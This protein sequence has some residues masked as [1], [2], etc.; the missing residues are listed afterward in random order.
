VGG[1]SGDETRILLEELVDAGVLATRD[2]PA[3]GRYDRHLLY[4]DL[5]GLDSGSAPLRLGEGVVGLVGM[6]G[7]GSSVATVLGTVMTFGMCR[8]ELATRRGAR[9]AMAS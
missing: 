1:L 8:E 9:R 6:G 7:I 2:V 3:D 4:Y 5:L